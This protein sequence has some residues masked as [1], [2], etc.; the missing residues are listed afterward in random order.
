MALVIEDGTGKADA[1][2]FVAR[3]DYI[4]EA[5]R[6]GVV[7]ADNDA[8]DVELTKAIDYILARPCWRGNE[9]YPGVQALPFPRTV[10]D[11]FGQLVYPADV[12]PSDVK[13]AQVLLA[14]AVH[15]GIDLMP[16]VSGGSAAITREK[17]GP[18]D[19]SYEVSTLYDTPSLPGPSSALAPYECG[20]GANFRT[21]RV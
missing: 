11:G 13:R 16:N 4:A 10:Y 21:R 18:I 1:N 7:I 19:T 12:V 20:Q 15:D 5:L 6:R 2:S 3:A 8:A 9:T 14:L 17:I